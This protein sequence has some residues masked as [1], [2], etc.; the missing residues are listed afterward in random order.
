[1]V[2]I[3]GNPFLDTLLVKKAL[4]SFYGIGPVVSRNVMARFHIHP[5]MKVG[6][7]K[8]Q[9]LLE[10]NA[11]L[12]T[13]NIDNDLRREMRDNIKK[14]RD[15]GCYRGKRHAMGLPV[16]GQN[17]KNQIKSAQRLNRI[18]RRN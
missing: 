1:M 16:R 2:F 17:T 8:D 4:E 10:L 11:Q 6:S 18:E 7:L 14:L 15:I 12:S 9:Q 13:M 3:L 5:T